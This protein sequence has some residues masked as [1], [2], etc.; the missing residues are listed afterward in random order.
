M[1]K[2]ADGFVVLPGNTQTLSIS[3]WAA[4]KAPGSRRLPCTAVSTTAK[5]MLWHD[6]PLFTQEASEPLMKVL[7]C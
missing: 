7:K 3:C 6:Q 5:G 1:A 2:H 4:L